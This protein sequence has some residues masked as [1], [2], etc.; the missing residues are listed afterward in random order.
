MGQKI[1]ERASSETL[2]RATHR[3]LRE[4]RSD[5]ELTEVRG[6]NNL[7]FVGKKR[8]SFVTVSSGSKFAKARIADKT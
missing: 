8:V 4:T 7:H 1:S 5:Y 6:A 3:V 2:P